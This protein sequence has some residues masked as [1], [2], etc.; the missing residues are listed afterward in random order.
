LRI[1]TNKVRIDGMIGRKSVGANSW[2][3]SAWNIAFH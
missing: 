3:R 2:T 1:R